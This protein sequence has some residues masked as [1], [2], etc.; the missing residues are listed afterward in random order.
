LVRTGL[1]RTSK[2]YAAPARPEQRSGY[3][4]ICARDLDR[5]GNRGGS[6]PKG[7]YLGLGPRQRPKAGPPSLRGGVTPELKREIKYLARFAWFFVPFARLDKWRPF[8][9]YEPGR[10]SPDVLARKVDGMCAAPMGIPAVGGQ[11]EAEDV[12]AAWAEGLAARG[13]A[14]QRSSGPAAPGPRAQA[15]SPAWPPMPAQ[16]AGALPV[17]YGSR[18]AVQRAPRSADLCTWPAEGADRRHGR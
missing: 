18:R 16:S 6:P 2:G 17:G 3:P 11:R 4:G 15:P 5:A 12:L 10:Y 1:P 13:G 14:V 8:L 7:R 9:D